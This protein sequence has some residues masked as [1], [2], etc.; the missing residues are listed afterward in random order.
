MR[1][2]VGVEY[3]AGGAVASG[4][5]GGVE[6]VDDQR[7]G[8]VGGHGIAD[9]PPGPD[10]EHDGE[11]QPAPAGGDAG[12]VAGPHPIRPAGAEPPAHQVLRRR[13]GAGRALEAGLAPPVDAADAVLAHEPL[14]ALVVDSA[15][16]LAQLRGHPGRTVG[17]AR[18]GVDGAY[19]THQLGL[20]Q[21]PWGG[22]RLV[23]HGPA[24]APGGSHRRPGT[25]PRSGTPRPSGQR[26]TNS[27]SLSRLLHP[28]GRRSHGSSR[29]IRSFE[30]SRRNRTSSERSPVVKP[31]RSLRSTRAWR[32]QLPR[33]VSPIPKS[34]ATCAIGRSPSNTSATASA[35]NSLVKRRLALPG[36]PPL[37]INDMDTS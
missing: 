16:L 6:G 26:P 21:L 32:T 19:R 30:F 3:H 13:S 20:G 37:S 23:A 22:P 31:G 9:D 12:D 34:R 11:V 24:G 15:A 17:T 28:Q 27:G 14:D 8:H 18:L 36:G 7:G 10:I 1:A 29:S 25:T 33:L 5:G 2:A 35:L 4:C